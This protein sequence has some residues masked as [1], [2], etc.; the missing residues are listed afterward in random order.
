[1]EYLSKLFGVT[2]WMRD[3][4][5]ASNEIAKEEKSVVICEERSEK[6][7]GRKS[8]ISFIEERILEN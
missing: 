6:D 3:F 7:V 5:T 4:L 8:R 2:R 1:L